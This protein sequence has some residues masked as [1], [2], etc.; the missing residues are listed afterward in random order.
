MEAKLHETLFKRFVHTFLNYF[1]TFPKHA[2]C[3]TT[4]R[5][6]TIRATMEGLVG[7]WVVGWLGDGRRLSAGRWFFLVFFHERLYR[8]NTYAFMLEAHLLFK[9]IGRSKGSKGWGLWKSL[10]LNVIWR[11][12]DDDAVW[13]C[14]YLP[15]S[16]LSHIW[17]LLPIF[18]EDCAFRFFLLVSRL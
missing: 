3:F 11:A 8:L 1:S 4:G 2:Q 12:F 10:W 18:G 16:S 9:S 6:T 14:A 5:G 7:K 15:R 13:S 17:F